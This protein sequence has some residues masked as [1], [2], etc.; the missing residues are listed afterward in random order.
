MFPEKELHG[1]SQET[2]IKIPDQAFE[3]FGKPSETDFANNFRTDPKEQVTKWT[4]EVTPQ[5]IKKIDRILKYFGVT[6]YSAY[7]PM[8][9]L[10]ITHQITSL[11]SGVKLA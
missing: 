9:I 6:I 5:D 7:D 8:P 1:L 2:G 10:P 11:Q 3:M 4:Q